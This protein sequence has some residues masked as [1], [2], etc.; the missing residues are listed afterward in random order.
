MIPAQ[1]VA[2]KHGNFSFQNGKGLFVAPRRHQALTLD[3]HEIRSYKEAQLYPMQHGSVLSIGDAM[4][5]LR[6]FAGFSVERA[7][8]LMADVPPVQEQPADAPTETYMPAS[9]EPLSSTFY[10]PPVDVAPRQDV[11]TEPTFYEV[12]SSADATQRQVERFRRR[13]RHDR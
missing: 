9:P 3:N 6:V 10:E 7:A 1:C 2:E 4:L 5:R 8:T 13:R 11:W 12:P